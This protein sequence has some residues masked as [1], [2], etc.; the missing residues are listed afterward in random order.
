[1]NAIKNV[2]TQTKQHSDSTF[3]FYDVMKQIHCWGSLCVWRKD[4]SILFDTNGIAMALHFC[5]ISQ[6]QLHEALLKNSNTSHVTDYFH[7]YD[8]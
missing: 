5:S 8:R 6:R 2:E 7:D 3:K 1:M 4:E